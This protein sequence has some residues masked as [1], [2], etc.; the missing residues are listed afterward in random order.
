MSKN[1]RMIMQIR[2]SGLCTGCGTCAG[3]CPTEAI[4]IHLS[5][6]VYVPE[7]EEEKCVS[8][9]LCAESCPGYSV[10]FEH[11]NAQIFGRQPDD[12]L[13]G[14]YMGC[15]IGRSNDVDIRDNSA[16]GGI[17]SQLLI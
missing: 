13:L 2:N 15:Y 1:T 8:C 14:N 11:L 7:I 12:R 3:V 5:E 16:S 17:A 9:G 4:K 6:V 10:D